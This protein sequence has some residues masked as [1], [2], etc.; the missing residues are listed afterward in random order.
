MVKS[1]SVEEA[2]LLILKMYASQEQIIELGSNAENSQSDYSADS[3]YEFFKMVE[4]HHN[5]IVS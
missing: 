5:Y 2:W 3:A 1:E 4:T